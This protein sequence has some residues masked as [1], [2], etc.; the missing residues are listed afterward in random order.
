MIPKLFIVVFEHS[1][2]YWQENSSTL[3][4]LG[5]INSRAAWFVGLA[6]MDLAGAAGGAAR[7][8]YDNWGTCLECDPEKG[9]E[10]LRRMGKGALSTSSGPLGGLF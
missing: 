5:V 4:S 10:L 3:S 7:F 6:L 2:C 1:Y 8:M 9:K